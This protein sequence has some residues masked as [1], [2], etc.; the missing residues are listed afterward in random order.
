MFFFSERNIQISFVENYKIDMKIKFYLPILVLFFGI[1]TALAQYPTTGLVGYYP[2][3]GNVLDSSTMNLDLS[4]QSNVVYGVDRFGN[5]SH[6]YSN[7]TRLYLPSMSNYASFSFALWVKPT[8]DLQTNSAIFSRTLYVYDVNTGQNIGKGGIYELYVEP[9][10]TDSLNVTMSLHFGQT[11]QPSYT[12]EDIAST[13]KRIKLDEWSHLG[14]TYDGSTNTLNL[15]VNGANK[16]T[17]EFGTVNGFTSIQ[18]IS[19]NVSGYNVVG[20]L[21]FGGASKV[22]FDPNTSQ[23][24]YVS[25]EKMFDGLIDDFFI[26]NRVLSDEEILTI[27]ELTNEPST[28]NINEIRMNQFTIS[29]NPVKSNLDLSSWEIGNTYTITTT[30]GQVVLMGSLNESKVIS[31]ET[32]V[33]GLYFVQINDN[34]G[35]IFS[36]KFIKE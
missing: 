19:A 20:D 23:V 13:S 11:Q 21:I 9:H 24:G 17:A 18:Y 15:Y 34:Q 30:S 3:D 1:K 7:E 12:W 14:I 6:A 22:G 26:Y 32:F 35:K 33:P 8:A 10:G 31:T 16:K 28:N 5:D 2:F 27:K 4:A 29:P 36:S 25:A